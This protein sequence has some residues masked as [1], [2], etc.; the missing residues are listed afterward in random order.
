MCPSD[1]LGLIQLEERPCMRYV[2]RQ[3]QRHARTDGSRHRTDNHARLGSS[4]GRAQHENEHAARLAGEHAHRPG[5][6][7][8][9]VGMP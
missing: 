2:L 4:G 6:A 1:F 8:H 5:N 7:E 9:R 3:K